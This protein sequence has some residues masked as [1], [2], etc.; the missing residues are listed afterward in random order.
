MG[1]LIL[2]LAAAGAIA[3]VG[4]LRGWFDEDS[5]MG[6]TEGFVPEAGPRGEPAADA[7]PEYGFDPQR[8]RANPA[9]RLRPP[10]REA[11]SHD[12]GSLVEFPPVI[13][14]GRIF[15]GTNLRLAVALS[16]DGERLWTRRLEGQVASSPALSGRLVLFTT[17]RGNVY[18]LDTRTSGV[19]WRV[20]LGSSIESSPLI[21]G[22]SAF[23]GTL[24]GR[25]LRLSLE[26]GSTVWTAQAT[27]DV[28]A[29]LALSGGNVIVGDYGGNVSAWS[30]ADG[31]LVW[32]TESPGRALRGSGRFYAGPAVAYGRVFIGNVNGRVLALSAEDGQVAWVRVVDDLVYSS[33]AVHDRLVYVGSYDG[34]LRALDAVTGAVRWSF[35]AGE[36]ISGSASVVGDVVWVSTLARVPSQGRTF[37]LDAATGRLLQTVPDGRYSPAVAIEGLLVLTGVRTIYGY[38]TE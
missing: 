31:R 7:W 27:G 35:D 8:T 11:W 30:R 24:D 5:V 36:R 38:V 21:V 34:R 16:T 33:A 18:A 29:S 20:R 25:V 4:L 14:G 22:D 37:A 10:L 28:K 15:F 2:L 1:G 19:V 13:A 17:T 3:G 23:V 32:R 12:A 6:S 26:D 9:L